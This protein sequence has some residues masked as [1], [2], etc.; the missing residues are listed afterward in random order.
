MVHEYY[1]HTSNS[2]DNELLIDHLR[3][4][5][6]LSALN[7]SFFN[8]EKICRQLGL[9]HDIGK[10]TENF[11]NVLLGLAH[12]Q[13][14]AIVSAMYF[15]SNSQLDSNIKDLMSLVMACHHSY[16][17]SDS[18]EF[19]RRQF[20]L[21]GS[22]EN[23]LS[24]YDD[25][26]SVAV[27]SD[28][29]YHDIEEYI[30]EEHLMLDL[31]NSDFN[32]NIS[33]DNRR[34]F[35]ARVLYSCLVDADYSATAEYDSPG[36]LNQ[37]YYSDDFLVDEYLHAFN[38]YYAD[39]INCAKDTPMNQIR[40][41][42]YD[43]CNTN[44]RVY[45]K[46]VTL[47]APTGSGKTLSLMKFALENAKAFNRRRIIIILPFLS[48]INQ[49]AEIYKSIFGE[50]VVLVDDSQTEYTEDSRVMSDRWSSPIIV[51]TSVKF[52]ETLFSCKATDIRRLHNIT[53]SVIV[54]D[55]CQTL[56]SDVLNSSIEILQ[57]L[58]EDY[59]CTVL[60]STAT[61][62]SYEYRNFSDVRPYGA[63]AIRRKGVCVA[64][65]QWSASEIIDDVD[66]LFNYYDKIRHVDIE[67]IANDVS[68]S[69]LAEYF[70]ENISS[71]Y[72]FNTVKQARCM[73]DALSN[74]YD[75]ADCYLITSNL[76]ATD[77]LFI[78]SEINQ[79]LKSGDVIKV[80]ATQCVEAGVDFDFPSGAR[81]FAPLD[82]IIQTLGRVNRN[83]KYHGKFLVFQGVNHGRYDYPSQSYHC[84]S[85]LS[86]SMLKN[87]KVSLYDKLFVDS[88]FKRLY[89]Y[90]GYAQDSIHLLDSMFCNDFQSVFKHYNLVDNKN[91]CILIVPSVYGD[92]AEY[93]NLV[94]NIIENGY[95]ITKGLMKKLS[96][97]TI[98]VYCSGNFDINRISCRL[99]FRK[100][101]S[102]TN[103]YLLQDLSAYSATGFNKVN[104]GSGIVL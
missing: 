98:S 16:L 14:H 66:W 29:E 17:Y 50:D 42:V 41:Y 88:Y 39:L 53:D 6:E 84:A 36:Y 73:Y 76:C 85:D 72:V 69:E 60:F 78:I 11:Q 75:K 15:N 27:A 23:V 91:C 65:M 7:G 49:N 86:L 102:N 83:G 100:F 77:K 70:D 2:R 103:W 56:P 87:N 21:P 10:H 19:C 64:K 9:L 92:M 32:I 46:F 18:R 33:T 101:D 96:K 35:C 31:S 28:T 20:K 94:S 4:T 5:A 80:A 47:T 79:R 52:F 97:Y 104:G 55:E 90:S 48:I 57:A 61:Q 89:S 37:Y 25:N 44:A 74:I 13:D 68:Y 58:T 71:L 34:M 81:E 63:L 45:D 99:K 82:S 26:K 1:A 12:K 22:F 67:T 24:T 8:H 95:T 54:F 30:A 51:T 62:P 43:M 38:Q 59:N 93:E 40:K 3:L